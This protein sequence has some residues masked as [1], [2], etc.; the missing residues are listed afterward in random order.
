MIFASAGANAAPLA[1]LPL[2]PFDGHLEDWGVKVNSSN[3]LIDLKVVSPLLVNT[4]ATGNCNPD[5][6]PTS[7]PL[8]LLPGAIYRSE[9][10]SGS[11]NDTYGDSQYVGPNT[12]GQN[13][14]VE[15]L[16][17]AA[18]GNSTLGTK[19]HIGIAS[20]IR[21]DNGFSRFA[22]GDIMIRVTNLTQNSPT[23]V[24]A[25]ETGGS[26]GCSP[27]ANNSTTDKPVGVSSC[28]APG[29]GS[30]VPVVNKAGT[31]NDQNDDGALYSLVSGSGATQGYTNTNA[32]AAAQKKANT[33]SS[34]ATV[35]ATELAYATGIKAGRIYENVTWRDDPIGPCSTGSDC[36]EFGGASNL[37]KTQM[38]TGT[39]VDDA[40]YYYSMAAASVIGDIIIERPH[41][42]IE[43]TLSLDSLIAYSG[44]DTLNV[45]VIWGP[46]CG[47]DR[48]SILA[49]IIEPEEFIEV[50][51]PGGLLFLGLGALALGWYR[52]RANA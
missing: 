39:F 31:I 11:N 34:L 3:K 24:F 45:E 1:T 7:A 43:A 21:P 38:L 30:F 19:L 10:K 12:G 40:E 28:P 44:G 50:P 51:A 16:G 18:S 5:I 2:D 52:R 27:N 26:F 32:G 35:M 8:G 6:G 46:A 17:V 48:L 29:A 36:T 4:C 25:L 23:K 13:Y 15:F 33:S 49:Q 14:D 22:P 41:A 47:N 42:I 9:D 20:G 37:Q